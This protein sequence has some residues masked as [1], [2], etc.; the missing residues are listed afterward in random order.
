MMLPTLKNATH[1]VQG[2]IVFIQAIY[3]APLALFLAWNYIFWTVPLM[4]RRIARGCLHMLE[5]AF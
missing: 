5:L 2:H 4:A 1:S 3:S